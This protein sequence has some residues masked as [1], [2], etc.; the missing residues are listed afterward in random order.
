MG[1]CMS[2]EE[3]EARA[4]TKEINRQLEIDGEQMN[5]RVKLLLLGA[6]ESGKSTI[7]KQ[8]KVIHERGYS[9]EECE[10]YTAVVYSNTVQSM[11]AIL[12]AMGTLQIP[13]ETQDAKNKARLV[14]ELSGQMDDGQMSQQL[15][16]IMYELWKNPSVQNCFSRSREYQLND[17]AE[18]FLSELPRIASPNYVPSVDDVLRTR[19]KTTGIVEVSFL[20]KE[21]YFQMFDV[22]GQRSERKKWIHCF[23]GVTAIIFCVSLSAYDLVLAEDEEMNRMHESM[24]L[25]DSICN[26]KW[27]IS[28]SIILFLNKIDLFEQKIKYS[29]LTICFQ[30]YRGGNNSEEAKKFIK[31]EFEC[32][33]RKQDTKHVY[34]HFTCAT[35]TSNIQ[36]VFDAIT[37]VIIRQNLMSCGLF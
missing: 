27:F 17:S 31:N 28:T 21:Y 36:F 8:M 10:S 14:F 19:V 30:Q 11:I 15:G 4:R 3:L 20:F 9:N 35:D 24:R 23:E 1:G 5:S 2:R 29:P 6:G 34:T 37:D 18:Y 26:N 32:L 25:F 22:G 13:F 16:Q 12:K 7:V 33:N